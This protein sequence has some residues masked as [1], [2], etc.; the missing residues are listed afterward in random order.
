MLALGRHRPSRG[1]EIALAQLERGNSW[2]CMI[3]AWGRD[4]HSGTA[5]A[6]TMARFGDATWWRVDSEDDVWLK[7]HA[8]ASS[9]GSS[10]G[11]AAFEDRS[12]V[13]I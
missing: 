13:D 2:S 4:T 3:E 1:R 9:G 7:G 11:R 5:G 6:V 12:T 10:W 8:I